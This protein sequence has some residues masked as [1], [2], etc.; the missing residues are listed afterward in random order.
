MHAQPE[1]FARTLDAYAA[2]YQW[3][4]ELGWS[5]DELG[6]VQVH[7]VP[8]PADDMIDLT[9]FGGT[10]LPVSEAD[11]VTS[12]D[13]HDG[14]R[15]LYVYRSTTPPELWARLK[16]LVRSGGPALANPPRAL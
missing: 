1:P 8:D 16:E 13:L 4:R 10:R 14:V 12:A 2:D 7:E 3:I 11:L 5:E 15:N 6:Q 9:N